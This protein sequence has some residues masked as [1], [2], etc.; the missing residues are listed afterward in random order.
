MPRTLLN[1][2]LLLLAVA[3][4]LALVGVAPAFA[5][6][7]DVRSCSGNP[8]TAP[9]AGLSGVD[10]AWTFETDDPTHLE[11]AANCPPMDDT[12]IDGL[13]AQT[14]LQSGA[15]P[16]SRFAQ[17]RF[18]A[19]SG[20]SLSRL[21]LW[22]FGAKQLNS[23]ELY[24]RTADGTTLAGSDCTKPPDQFSCTVGGAGVIA[25]WTIDT[26]SYRVGIACTN[27]T[28]CATGFS[29]HEAWS[30][31]YAAIVTVNDTTPPTASGG[32][33]SL[34]AGG[35]L[36]GAVA[37]GVASAS[38]STG[39]RNLQVRVDGDRV[40][41]T[42]PERA[43][44]F[45]RRSPCPNLSSAESFS[46][47]SSAIGDGTWTARVGVLD[48]GENFTAA[49]TQT[50]TVDNTPP[51]APTPSS[52]PSLTVSSPSTT[53]SW[54]EP[55]GQVSPIT[56][57]HITMCGPAGCQTRTQAAGAGSG[58]ATVS[59]GGYGSYTASVALQDAAGNFSA[60]QAATWTIT[61]ASPAVPVPQPFPK[62]RPSVKIS[63]RLVLARPIVARDRRTITVR[64]SVAPSVSGRVTAQAS[65]R[66]RGRTRTITR[67]ATI[68]GRRYRT[69]LRLPSR[70]WRTAKV[71]VRYP[72]NSMRRSATIVRPVG[73]RRR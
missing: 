48:A 32:S 17:W 56:T 27:D 67:H 68:R 54:T 2:T 24:T 62:P 22:R 1:H 70:A 47:D 49:A 44:D 38:D 21:R 51:L 60:N 69:T 31:I 33:G 57:A 3:G 53:I 12:G 39:I 13:T 73:Q 4:T 35:Y 28:S 14:T 59:L 40:V 19:P 71:T 18:D 52:P 20:T 55:G 41:G 72:G 10:D 45:T 61:Y 8:A 46:F 30:S 37:A 50:I 42:A 23:W 26:S 34:F 29:L 36:R 9:P 58:S 16:Q 5:G 25:D 11:S 64:G 65:A 66:I 43:C 63:P 15:T 7:Y 6:T